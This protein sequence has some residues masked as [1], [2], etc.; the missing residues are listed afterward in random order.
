MFRSFV[1]ISKPTFNLRM[2][3]FP[4][5]L[6]SFPLFLYIKGSGKWWRSAGLKNFSKLHIHIAWLLLLMA[7]RLRAKARNVEELR[8][9]TNNDD[10][11]QFEL[12]Q[13]RVEMQCVCSLTFDD[14][15]CLLVV[16]IRLVYALV[17]L[18]PVFPSLYYLWLFSAPHFSS[19]SPK[20]INTQE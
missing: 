3:I 7:N 8:E 20:P 2:W 10:M 1:C 15:P 14:A 12:Q 19:C 11:R 5:L 18:Q 17:T 6:C 16:S 13:E 4:S 9:T